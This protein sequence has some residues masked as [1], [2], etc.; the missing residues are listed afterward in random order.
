MPGNAGWL[1]DH[2]NQPPGLTV[3]AAVAPARS[4]MSIRAMLDTTPSNGIP[5][6]H[7]VVWRL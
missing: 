1:I 4:S 3:V 6:H 7:S 2:A 5:S